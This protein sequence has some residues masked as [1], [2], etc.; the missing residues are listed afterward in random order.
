VFRRR[1]TAISPEEEGSMFLRTLASTRQTAALCRAA[2]DQKMILRGNAFVK[3]DTHFFWYLDRILHISE[4]SLIQSS[5]MVLIS[6]SNAIEYA[7][8]RVIQEGRSIF[9]EAMLSVIV[10]NT[11]HTNMYL[12][13]NRYQDRA[14]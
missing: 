13:L 3:L 6:N 4:Q 14:V 7:I 9:W 10:G 11:V 12:I 1:Q 8:Y 5:S 2:E